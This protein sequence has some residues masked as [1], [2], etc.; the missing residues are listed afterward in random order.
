[1][2][3]FICGPDVLVLLHN[4]YQF[5]TVL[6]GPWNVVTHLLSEDLEGYFLL[7]CFETKSQ[8][9]PNYWLFTFKIPTRFVKRWSRY[10]IDPILVA[11]LV[12][13]FIIVVLILLVFIFCFAL[14]SVI[15]F[16]TPRGYLGL[17]VA[18]GLWLSLFY[19]IILSRTEIKYSLLKPSCL[20][21]FRW[22]R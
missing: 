10:W 13:S 7:N 12:V 3:G 20:Y 9:Y 5:F 8:D 22:W 1:M 15:L 18:H 6:H 17:V 11:V 21:R 4:A 16:W 14:V 2:V 19:T